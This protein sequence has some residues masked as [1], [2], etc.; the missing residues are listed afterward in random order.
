MTSKC[1]SKASYIISILAT[2]TAG[3]ILSQNMTKNAVVPSSIQYPSV[4]QASPGPK[5]PFNHDL[6]VTI[7]DVNTI[8]AP[9]IIPTVPVVTAITGFI[10]RTLYVVAFNRPFSVLNV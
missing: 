2:P 8:A 6:N 3:S 5:T 10:T 9:V 4:M 1:A 7:V